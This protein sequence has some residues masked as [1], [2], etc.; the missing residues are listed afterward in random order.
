MRSSRSAGTTGMAR[1]AALAAL[2]LAGMASAGRSDDNPYCA[3]DQNV[4]VFPGW[5]GGEVRCR[6]G[7]GLGWR[8]C[9]Y[10]LDKIGL[11]L[12]PVDRLRRR[13]SA[14]LCRRTASRQSCTCSLLDADGE[15]VGRPPSRTI[16]LGPHR[17]S[18][19][20]PPPLSRW[21]DRDNGPVASLQNRVLTSRR[22]TPLRI[23]A[24]PFA[25][26]LSCP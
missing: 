21:S 14:S 6:E 12:M 13:W 24:I 1:T 25:T 9:D 16:A 19:F 26:S 22:S 4:S 7:R 23:S 8:E 2:M 10:G 3:M 5:S 17:I 20:S 15:H 11:C 18:C